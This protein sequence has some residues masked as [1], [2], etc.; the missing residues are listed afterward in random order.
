MSPDLNLSSQM[1][2]FILHSVQLWFQMVTSRLQDSRE[3]LRRLCLFLLRAAVSNAL[4]VCLFVFYYK[5]YYYFEEPVMSF[6]WCN[7]NHVVQTFS[8]SKCSA[9]LDSSLSL[10]VS[11]V[12][13]RCKRRREDEPLKM[14]DGWQKSTGMSVWSYWQCSPPHCQP[15]SSWTHPSV[16]P[17]SVTP[18]A[19]ATVRHENSSG[20]RERS[21][22]GHFLYLVFTPLSEELSKAVICVTKHLNLL[23]QQVL[24]P[25]NRG[26][27]RF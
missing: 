4:N 15:P 16:L 14:F 5:Q 21:S 24:L 9:S 10:L 26:W 11:W 6:G 17:T 23:Q 7:V 20:G 27:V 19:D 13:S 3:L 8:K 1:G 2:L 25:G 22:S 18:S 12:K